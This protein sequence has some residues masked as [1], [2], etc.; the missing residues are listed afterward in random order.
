MKFWNDGVLTLNVASSSNNLLFKPEWGWESGEVVKSERFIA[1]LEAKCSNSLYITDLA[2]HQCFCSRFQVS[3]KLDI[4]TLSVSY[5]Q[6]I[7]L[8]VAFIALLAMK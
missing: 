5:M 3:C 1:V 6:K 2:L 4:L 8:Q 7:T